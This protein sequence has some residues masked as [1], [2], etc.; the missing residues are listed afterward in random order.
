VI[1]FSSHGWTLAARVL[2]LEVGYPRSAVTV[3]SSVQCGFAN[4]ARKV[5]GNGMEGNVAGNQ[6]TKAIPESVRIRSHTFIGKAL[7]PMPIYP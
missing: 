4:H 7:P 3:A 5:Y 2:A 1:G 6:V